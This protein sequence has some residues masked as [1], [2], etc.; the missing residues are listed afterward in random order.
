MDFHKVNDEHNAQ[1]LASFDPHED[2]PALDHSHRLWVAWNVE[3]I[4]R[5]V[6]IKADVKLG[7]PVVPTAGLT[8]HDIGVCIFTNERAKCEEILKKQTTPYY[9]H[10]P[11]M[12]LGPILWV[13]SSLN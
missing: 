11:C 9:Y 12:F 10:E 1:F 6:G 2:R 4:L 5:L 13:S 8:Y 3:R 7:L